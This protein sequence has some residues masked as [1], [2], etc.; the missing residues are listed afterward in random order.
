MNPSALQ[1]ASGKVS[2]AIPNG[3]R[4][5]VK[6][7]TMMVFRLDIFLG[8]V[9]M[10]FLTEIISPIKDNVPKLAMNAVYRSRKRCIRFDVCSESCRSF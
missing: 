7:R 3:G 4:K 10:P 5:M 1:I 6:S 9:N 2:T 8:V